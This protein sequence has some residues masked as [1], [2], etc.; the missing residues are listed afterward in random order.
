MSVENDQFDGVSLPF[1]VVL[2][3]GE[4]TGA[5]SDATGSLILLE[6]EAAVVDSVPPPP[7]IPKKLAAAD[8]RELKPFSMLEKGS[9]S[10]W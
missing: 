7:P 9:S 10:S 6:V 4:T 1:E 3:V 2:T 5:G 8:V